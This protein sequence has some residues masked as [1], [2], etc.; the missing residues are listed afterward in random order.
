MLSDIVTNPVA[1]QNSPEAVTEKTWVVG[2]ALVTIRALS[3]IGWVE[4][5]AR[6][7]SGLTRIL[8]RIENVPM[9]GPGEVDPDMFSVP[10]MLSMNHESLGEENKLYQVRPSIY[11]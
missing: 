11:R 1:H 4:V 5:T 8:A 3:R 10:A 7:A 6:R 9:V 2:N